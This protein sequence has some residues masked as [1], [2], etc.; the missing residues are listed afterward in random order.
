MSSMSN[1]GG[2]SAS[3]LRTGIIAMTLVLMTPGARADDA[4]RDR[5]SLIEGVH[6]IA[7]PGAP[8]TIAVDAPTATVIVAGKGDGGADVPVVAS[9]HLGRGRIVAFA[10]DGYLGGHV[11]GTGA[12]DTD[13]LLLNA[14]KWA[15][16]GRA[17]PRVG[18]VDGRALR[19]MLEGDG[20]DAAPA[21]LDASVAGYDVVVLTPFR[22]TPEQ[23]ALLRKYVSA[24]GGLIVAATG[25]G[26]Q[27]L[28]G[29]RPMPEF[30]GNRLLAGTGLAWTD[31]FAGKTTSEG[32]AVRPQI[33]PMTNVATALRAIEGRRDI[34]A[35]DVACALANIRLAL[36][37]IPDDDP[38]RAA[39]QSR[40]GRVART[41]LVPSRKRPVRAN[42]GRR[43][44]AVGLEAILAHN[45]PV[46]KLRAAAAAR[47]FPGAVPS[48]TP[49]V[50]RTIPIDTAVPGWHTLGLYAAPGASI[51]VEVPGSAAKLGLSVQ[52]GSH[53]DELWHLNA[54]ERAP[55]LVRR[56]PI[57]QARTE[58]ASAF[59]GTIYIDVPERTPSRRIEVKVA[60]AVASPRFRLGI[61]SR[62]EWKKA[63]Q[64]AA[65]WAELEG[66]NVI[67]TVP[68]ASIRSLD[69]PEALVTLWDRIV[70]A[71]D[72]AVSLPRRTRP[73]RIVADVQ[74]SAGYMHS[75]YPIMVPIDDSL[76]TA[77]SLARL[78]REGSW[79][80][81]HE[82]GHNH[83]SGEWTFDGTGEVTNNVLV[84]YVFD[85]VLGLPFDSG[86]EAIRDR[87]A[88][89]DR[90]RAHIAAGAPFAKWKADPFL[91]LMMYIQLYEGFGWKPF[92]AVFA[93]YRRLPD[94]ER[95]HSDDAKRDQWLVRFSR[96]CGRNL[97]PFFQAWGV[98]T[99]ETGRA[100]IANLP[101]WMPAGFPSIGRPS[102]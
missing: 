43:R 92:E 72:A 60:G 17:R 61:T 85:R 80:H 89:A 21:A 101:D 7:A 88:R 70:A 3:R 68:S 51:R 10:H 26:W 40:L 58:A 13:R 6:T 76:R 54:W 19:A 23:S 98:P 71:Q 84:L 20:I 102:N 62:T 32:Y 42:D 9:G 55:Q 100:E 45:T 65:P 39:V 63:R 12:G 66:H 1:R 59:G 4:D 78:R 87:K 96:A 25:W 64:L 53:T 57:R 44:L 14:V 27:Q 5:A 28:N 48:G 31:G 18:L 33:A 38:L 34:K 77:L 49:R 30:P 95:P 35:D 79:G 15:A 47:E 56:F 16:G 93:E 11:R 82:L 29:N 69:D 73:E 97:G 86:H 8:G 91:A 22:V 50:E 37:S 81:F 46:S 24:G 75:G 67:F 2:R 83:Q 52:I 74:I 90:I 94:R 99:S 36:R 41:D